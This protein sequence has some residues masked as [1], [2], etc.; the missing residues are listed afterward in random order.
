[1]CFPPAAL[2]DTGWTSERAGGRGANR[3]VLVEIM[4]RADGC[5][6]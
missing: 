5:G 6:G 1:M 4:S 2:W 3:D